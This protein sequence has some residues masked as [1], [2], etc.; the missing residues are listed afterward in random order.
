MRL[1]ELAVSRSSLSLLLTILLAAL[2]INAFLNTPRSVDPHFP[3]PSVVIVVAQPGA[4]AADMEQTIARPIEE[5]LQALDDIDDINSTSTDGVTVIATEFDWSG[6]ADDYFDEVVREVSAIRDTLPDGI[7]EIEYRRIRTTESKLLQF[8]LVSETSSFRRMEKVAEDLR[9]VLNNDPDVRETEIWGLERPEIQVGL[10]SGR[11]AEL[12]LPASTILDAIGAAGTELPAGEVSSSDRRFNIEAGGAFSNLDE[13]RQVAVRSS[14]GAVVRVDDVAEV[15]WVDP[16]RT[17]ITRANGARAIYVTVE[18]KDGANAVT[19]RDRL[20]EKVEDFKQVLPVDTQLITAFDQADDIERVISVL[21]RDFLI[22]LGL[23]IITLLPLGPR[24]SVVVMISIPLSLGVGVLAM[25]SIGFTLNQLAVSG[26]ILALGLV[27]DDSIV[28]VENVSRRIREGMDRT[29]AA[30]AG[31]QQIL[32]PVVG[33]TAILIFAFIPLVFLPEGAGRFTRSLPLSVIFSVGGSL[34]IALTIIPFLASRL[35]K[36][37]DDPEGNVFLRSVNK[38]VHAFYRPLLHRAL[39]APKRTLLIATAA[40][41]AAFGLVPVLGF[42]LFPAADTPYFT[43]DVEATEGASVEKTDKVIRQ[44]AAIIAEEDMVTGYFENVGAGN[45]QVFYNKPRPETQSN[46]GQILVTIEE[47]N[48]RDGPA[49]LQRLRDRFET[50]PDAR[51]VIAPFINGPPIT[52]PIEISVIGPDL[53]VL[54]DL[55]IEIEDAIRSTSGA[56]DITNPLALDRVDLDLGLD[57]GKAAALNVAPGTPRQ[58]VRL[59]LEGQTAAQLRDEEGDAYD[60]VV[61]LPGQDRRNIDELD[62]VYVPT[63]SGAAIPLSQIATPR[64]T[65]TPGLIERYQL[66]RVATITSEVAPDALPSQVTQDALDKINAIELPPGYSLFVGG[67][68]EASAASFAGLGLIAALSFFGVLIVLVLEFGTF[69]L[70]TISLGVVPLGMFGGL[71]A[72]FLTGNSLSYTAIIGFIALIGIEIKNSVLLVDFT[73]QLRDQGVG[74]RDAIEQA[75]EIRFLPVLLTS[76]T[77]IG[78]LMPLAIGGAALY[79]PLAWVIIGGLVSS[80]LLSRIVTPV[81]YLIIERDQ[82]GPQST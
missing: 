7:A 14:N 80:T 3:I 65:S 43:V 44:V 15:K 67:E 37:T 11:L 38:G 4:D 32:V 70:V 48:N 8:A 28:V 45:P 53:A 18:Q 69:R 77:A 23:V 50:I 66:Q 82:N 1:V 54:K 55:S 62:Q 73:R 29:A 42:S 26:F 22:A 30:I 35:L 41:V 27:V 13:V 33:T 78:G 71:V 59:A 2:S 36:Q 6:N 72:L 17:H 75:G 19:T 63:R 51:V 60:V 68:A 56:R 20:I 58:A 34:I 52:A 64:L 25:S 39:E 46:F 81:L 76:V 47:W 24:A 79:S 74:L 57:L 31:T 21:T 5:A 16:P 40:V 61:S 49:L 12:Q 10:N 9:D